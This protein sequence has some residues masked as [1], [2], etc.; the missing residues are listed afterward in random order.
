MISSFTTSTMKEKETIPS[1][2][3]IGA[4]KP[5][6]EVPNQASISRATGDSHVQFLNQ[7]LTRGTEQ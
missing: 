6:T 2:A 1:S 7:T 3:F 4:R 5:F